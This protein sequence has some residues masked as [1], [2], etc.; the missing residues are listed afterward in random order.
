MNY[1]DAE[2]EIAQRLNSKFEASGISDLYLAAPVPETEAEA[3]S[4]YNKIDIARA[5]IEYID[6]TY[7]PDTGNDTAHVVERA[8]FKITFESRKRRGP[9]GVYK[10]M[11]LAKLFLNGFKPSNAD[12]L[13]PVKFERFIV[14]ENAVQ[15]SIDFE[16]RTLNVELDPS[17]PS[18]PIEPGATYK[19]LAVAEQFTF[20]S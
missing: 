14:D 4:W 11:E 15:L 7:D 19:E 13:T 2:E 10:L 5:S 3:R 8:R 17:E 12:R 20:N 6:S 18:L 1:G 9:G 16:C